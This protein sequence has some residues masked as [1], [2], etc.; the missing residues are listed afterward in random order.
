M[1]IDTYHHTS[2]VISDSGDK[3]LTSSQEWEVKKVS[4]TTGLWELYW[5]F[6]RVCVFVCMCL[7]VV[8]LPLWVASFPPI[9]WRQGLSLNMKITISTRLSSQQD[10]SILLPLPFQHWDYWYMQPSLAIS[11]TL[12][13]QS[14]VLM[15]AQQTHYLLSCLSCLCAKRVFKSTRTFLWQARMI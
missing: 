11:W 4:V 2:L 13:I 8:S 1:I 15:Y 5:G 14:Q 9:L 12:R 6:L 10:P 3:G 7:H